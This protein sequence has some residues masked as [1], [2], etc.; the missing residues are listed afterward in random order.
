MAH[1]FKKYEF[2]NETQAKTRIASLPNATDGDGN[3]YFTHSHAVV[4]LGPQWETLPVFDEEGEVQTEGVLKTTYSVDVLWTESEITTIDD[5][6]NNIISYPT[7][8]VS[9]E[10]TVEGNGVHTFAGH[11]FG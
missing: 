6:N 10:I 11:N 7:G 2:D 4:E 9:K 5:N 1:I 3:K 8:W